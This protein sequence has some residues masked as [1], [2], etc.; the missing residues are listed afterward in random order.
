MVLVKTEDRIWHKC[1]ASILPY[2]CM[3]YISELNIDAYMPSL[4]SYP[5]GTSKWTYYLPYYSTFSTGNFRVILVSLSPFIQTYS[6]SEISIEYAPFL[7]PLTITALN[8]TLILNYCRNITRFVTLGIC[9]PYLIFCTTDYVIFLK[10][11]NS[12]YHS[13]IEKLWMAFQCQQ[14]KHPY[15]FSIGFS[16]AISDPFFQVHF[17]PFNFHKCTF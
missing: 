2:H 12:S 17:L 16:Q 9:W 11:Q 15:I 8:Q 10:T 4:L 5:T 13:P 1:L 7:F 14:E 6:T 3:E